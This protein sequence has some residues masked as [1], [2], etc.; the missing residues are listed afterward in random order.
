MFTQLEEHTHSIRRSKSQCHTGRTTVR[1]LNQASFGNVAQTRNSSVVQ[2]RVVVAHPQETHAFCH[3]LRHVPSDQ[4]KARTACSGLQLEVRRR[5]FH[6]VEVA[7]AVISWRSKR[8]AFQEK[9]SSPSHAI[10]AETIQREALR[11]EL[12][13]EE[14]AAGCDHG[15]H[16]KQRIRSDCSLHHPGTVPPMADSSEEEKMHFRIRSNGFLDAFSTTGS[17]SAQRCQPRSSRSQ[18][19]RRTPCPVPVQRGASRGP[20]TPRSTVAQ[21]SGQFHAHG[22]PLVS[23]RRAEMALPPPP[24]GVTL[25]FNTNHDFNG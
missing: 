4:S 8:R 16:A 7:D 6:D 21:G 10:A 15:D 13:F 3:D 2:A 5:D 19:S 18:T 1:P 12:I 20:A 14:L 24:G 9:L 23:K 17:K 22:H 25:A 11:V